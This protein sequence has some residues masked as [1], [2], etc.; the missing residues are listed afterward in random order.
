MAAFSFFPSS[1]GACAGFAAVCMLF[2]S[3]MDLARAEEG[4]DAAPRL[5]SLAEIRLAVAGSGRANAS[6]RLEGTVCAISS[7][8][9]LVALQDESDT[10]LLDCPS[11]PAGAAA[12]KRILLEG[13]LCPIARGRHAIHIGTAPL[14][15][16]DG[17]HAD[18]TRSTSVFL[19]EGMQ[20]L[21]VDWFNGLN[22]FQWNRITFF[23]T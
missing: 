11:L 6:F 15:V 7:D 3:G 10:L 19:E 20:P 17:H 16:I 23:E 1:R 22:L 18:V 21:R 12:G 14:I 9:R 8:R 2:G 4:P 13:E 5:I